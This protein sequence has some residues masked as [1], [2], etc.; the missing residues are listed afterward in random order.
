[1]ADRDDVQRNFAE[2][3]D[4]IERYAGSY[5]DDQWTRSALG[6]WDASEVL[7]HVDHMAHWYHER[8]DRALA[9]D[10][11]QPFP[12]DDFDRWTVEQVAA[13]PRALPRERAADFGAT[14]RAYAERLPDVWGTPMW[15]VGA[16]LTVGQHAALAA[17]EWHAHAWDLARVIGVEH[18]PQQPATLAAGAAEAV[19]VAQRNR[20]VQRVVP[21]VAAHQRDP[22]R[23]V[24]KR[25]GRV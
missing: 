20:T 12:G 5:T 3:V 13:A 18:R 11:S 17:V 24:L 21:W 10:L 23:S 9:G 7:T 8:V 15:H 6:V 22:W 4:A 14:A 2:G 1:M 19:T 16:T 25:L